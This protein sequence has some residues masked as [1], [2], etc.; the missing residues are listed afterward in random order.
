MGVFVPARVTRRLVI[1]SDALFLNE[2]PFDGRNMVIEY[3]GLLAAPAHQ[4]AV[5]RETVAHLLQTPSRCDEI[6]F[7]ALSDHE[8][9]QLAGALAEAGK[10]KTLEESTTWSVDLD[11]FDHGVDAYLATLSKNRRAQ[12]R[13]SLSAY[14][15]RG[16]LRL[17]EASNVKEAMLFFDGLKA[18]HTVR[19]KA[20]GAQGSFANP[21]WERFHRVLIRSRFVKGEIQL[22]RVSNCNGAVGYLYNFIWCKCVYVLQTGFEIGEDKRLMPGYV[23]HCLAIAYNKRKGMKVYDLMHGDSL[24]KRILCDHS[25]TL[26][27]LVLQRKRLKFGLEDF[28]VNL[29]RAFRRQ[30]L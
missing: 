8:V 10:F 26:H 14:E 12:V 1:R 15:E 29:A 20:K 30:A 25:Q 16:P 21:L 11:R 23:M 18:L 7:S 5:Y 6:F 19:W 9:L 17:D 4:A 27:W 13:R 28:A 24:Y 22:I 3:N 2:Y